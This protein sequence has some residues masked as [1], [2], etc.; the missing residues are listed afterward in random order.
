MA[1]ENAKAIV[2]DREDLIREIEEKTE[3]FK[4]L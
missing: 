1:S 2:E 4:K 3:V